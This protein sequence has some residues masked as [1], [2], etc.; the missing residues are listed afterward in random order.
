MA[1]PAQEPD[2]QTLTV[3]G[4]VFVSD[5]STALLLGLLGFSATK[6]WNAAMRY[7]KERWESTGK[8]PTYADLD[9]AIKQERPLWY[10]RLHSQS[11]QAVLEELWQSYRSWFALRKKGDAK[12]KPP[13][14]RRKTDLSSVTFKQYAVKWNQRTKTVR[15]SMPKDI[16][17]KQFLYLTV[18]MPEGTCLAEDNIQLARLVYCKGHWSIHIVYKIKLPELK[19]FGE[20]MAIDLGMKHLAA[21][22]CTD[23]DTSLWPGGELAAL[24]RY[25]DKQKSTTTRSRSQKSCTLNQKR[26]RQ[27]SHLLHSFTK[28]LVRDA[29]ARGVSTVIV[30]NLKDIRDG[31]NW[32]DSGNQQFH[33]WPFDRIVKMLTYKARLKGIR[34]VTEPE[35]YTSQTCCMCGTKRKAGR[36][37]R[38]LYV[39]NQC[40]AVIN[41]DVNGAINILKRYLPEQISVSWSS[42]CLAQPAVNR[43]AWRKTRPL[44]SAHKPGTWQTSLPHPRIESAVALSSNRA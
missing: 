11:A 27:R 5:D 43:F 18:R 36:I 29:D 37:H 34:V 25:F 24:E 30:G 8:I 7:T 15:L 2:L 6:L 20:T 26:S 16:Y 22:A 23:G 33:K 40:G 17:G 10:H 14:Y 42:G 13:G 19:G 39:C 21:T 35:D 32:G 28:S 4:K 1:E 9:I 41:A 44:V 12:T 38:G 31:K 3:V